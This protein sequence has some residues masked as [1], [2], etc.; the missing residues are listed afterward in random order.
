MQISS[1]RHGDLL[2]LTLD[3]QR[4]DAAVALKFKEAMRGAVSGHDGRVVLDMHNIAFLDSSGLGALVAGMKMLG[5]GR[6]LELARCGPIVSKVLKLTRMDAV[7]ILHEERP[8][9]LGGKDA[10]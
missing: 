5:A 8:W 2:A 1:S 4:L 7:F 6:R 10:A 3:D 9:T